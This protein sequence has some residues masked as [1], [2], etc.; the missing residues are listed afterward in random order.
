MADN[1]SLEPERLAGGGLDERRIGE[2]GERH[3][4]DP[5]VVVVRGRRGR[6]QCE[7]CLAAPARAG[8]R[9]QPDVGPPQQQRELVD[10]P[11]AT[12]ERCRRDWQVRLVQ[13]LQRREDVCPELEETLRRAQVLQPVQAE[14][15]HIGAG[16]VCRRLRQKHLP[17]VPGGGDP[18]RPVHVEPHVSLVGP[19]RL[20][21]MQ[22]HPHTHWAARERALR[23]GSRRHCIG[24]TRK[25]DEEGV[26]LR[27]DLDPLVPPPGVSQRTA[28]L[29]KHRR[30]PVAQ[31]PEQPGRSLDVGEEERHGPGRESGSHLVILSPSGPRHHPL[32]P[33]GVVQ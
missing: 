21:R 33:S 25:C 7:S 15:A 3:P 11:L 20:A 23:L 10:L 19:E 6:L 31:L 5:T 27:V 17:A 8:Q 2:R 4:P 18:R 22:A 1:V 14:V 24:R 26:A 29:G 9:H 28:V 30:I 16:K 12:E 13:R 32:A